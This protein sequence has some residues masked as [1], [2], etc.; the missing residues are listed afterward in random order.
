ALE[1]GADDYLPKPFDV[2]ELLARVTA[3]IRR[4]QGERVIPAKN[5]LTIG[6]FRV[7]LATREAE[8]LQGPQVLSEK[9]AG[10]LEFL[11]RCRGEV[12]SRADIL[13]EV[14][15]MDATP[16][17]RTVDNFIVKL[18]K[19]FEPDPENPRHFITVRGRGYRFQP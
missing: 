19:M 7:N 14:W 2:A 13:D 16:T 12:V 9:E 10:L 15:G 8:T 18:R 5:I 6:R 3:I 1:Q 17:E 11:A 4:S